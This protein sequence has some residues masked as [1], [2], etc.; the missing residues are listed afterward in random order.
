MIFFRASKRQW[1]DCAK[2]LLNNLSAPQTFVEYLTVEQAFHF[3][4]SLQRTRQ[5]TF[6]PGE[7]SLERLRNMMLPFDL[8]DM[9]LSIYRVEIETARG[10][11][12]RV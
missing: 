12:N 8:P 10:G 2:M 5:C 1:R 7:N 11:T 6:D 4:V 3:S 9:R